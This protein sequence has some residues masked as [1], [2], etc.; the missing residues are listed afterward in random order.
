MNVLVVEDDASVARFI[1]QAVTEAGYAAQVVSDG[2]SASAM[3]KTLEFDLILL[4]VMLPGLDGFAVCRQLRAAHVSTPILF[5]TARDTLEDKIE[6]LDTGADDY[7]VKPF[8]IGEL[9]AR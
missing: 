1:R 2:L 4:D 8:Q 3:A 7:I 5:I 9:L 6:G